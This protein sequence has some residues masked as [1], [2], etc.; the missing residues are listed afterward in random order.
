LRAVARDQVVAAGL[1]IMPTTAKIYLRNTLR[2]LGARNRVETVQLAR[3]PGLLVIR[4]A[5]PW[6]APRS[7]E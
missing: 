4:L 1:A 7:W 2:N 5:Q 3:R 6:L